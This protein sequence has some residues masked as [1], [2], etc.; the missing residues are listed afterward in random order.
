[1]KTIYIKFN[2][3]AEQVRGFYQLAT[4][5]WVTSLP[6]EIYKVPID[7]LQILDTQYISYRRAT[8]KEVAKAHDKIRACFKFSQNLV[9]KTERKE[10]KERGKYYSI[11]S[12]LSLPPKCTHP[13]PSKE[14][15]VF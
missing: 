1:M 9:D 11:L 5:A 12:T 14:G 7:S 6:D 10:G 8:D 3:R 2:S 15:T 13:C 4:R